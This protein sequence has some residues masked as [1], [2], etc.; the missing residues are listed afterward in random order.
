MAVTAWP[1]RGNGHRISILLDVGLPDIDGLQ[2][3]QL[4]GRTRDW[5]ACR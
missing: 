1:L 4:I 3:L 2:V 5:R